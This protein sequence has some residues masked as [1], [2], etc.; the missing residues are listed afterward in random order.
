MQANQRAVQRTARHPTYL[1][2]KPIS[3]HYI[4]R[5]DIELRANTG[6]RNIHNIW[7]KNQD[8][9][10]KGKTPKTLAQ[11]RFSISKATIRIIFAN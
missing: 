1:Q 9:A 4:A 3:N 6:N 7:R 10:T 2:F 8:L 11:H 5:Q